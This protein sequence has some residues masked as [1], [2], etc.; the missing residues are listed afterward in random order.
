MVSPYVAKRKQHRR[1]VFKGFLDSS[2][3]LDFSITKME[4]L[5]SMGALNFCK[6][7]FL[8]CFHDNT[9]NQIDAKII[10]LIELF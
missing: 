1:W 4:T 7:T 2:C 3:S 9:F 10:S 8:T 5:G 6:L